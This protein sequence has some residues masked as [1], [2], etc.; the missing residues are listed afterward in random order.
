MKYS[1]KKIIIIIIIII[2]LKIIGIIVRWHEVF[3]FDS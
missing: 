3:S 1:K 2:I